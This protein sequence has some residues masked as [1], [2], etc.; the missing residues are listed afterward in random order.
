MSEHNDFDSPWKEII[1]GYFPEFMAFFFLDVYEQIDWSR[2]PVF[3]D[4]E[5][6]SV[7]PDAEL[8]R[9]LVDKLVQVWRRDGTEIWVLIHVEVQGQEENA[10]DERMFV[11]HYRLFDKY[12]CPIMSLAVLTDE[13]ARW[14]PGEYTHELW[15]CGIRFWFPIVKM[16][17]Y[18][19][20]QRAL[21]ASNNPF[22]IVVLTHLAAQATRKSAPSRAQLKVQLTRRL[23]KHG[24]SRKQM[25]DLYRFIDWLL[26]LPDDLDTMVWQQIKDFEEE[27]QMTYISTAEK[28]GMQQGLL[29]G[30][31]QG[32][33]EGRKEAVSD[34]VLRMASKRFGVLPQQ[35]HERL[36]ALPDASMNELV[37]ALLD[38]NTQDELVSWL[39]SQPTAA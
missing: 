16:L 8:G 25:I 22:A 6:Q 38:F 15:G 34:I 18:A 9:R 11:Y 32:K 14:K 3:L 4:K 1:E 2:T 19:R 30:L 5:L 20:D 12:R 36:I 31:Q 29:Q 23:Y 17:E 27:E 35:V 10:F 24:F 26:R 28:I 39:N 33:L 21:E 7:S 13:Q 37:L